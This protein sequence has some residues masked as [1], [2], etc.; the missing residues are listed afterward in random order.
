MISILVV[1]DKPARYTPFVS[2]V[3]PKYLTVENIDFRGNLKDALQALE[4]K[5]YDLVIVDMMLPTNPWSAAPEVDGG[6]TLL[7]AIRTQDEIRRPQ[8]IVGITSAETDAAEVAKTFNDSSWV[9]LRDI[10]GDE[11]WVGRLTDLVSHISAVTKEEATIRSTADV[12]VIT[13][14]RSPEFEALKNLPLNWSDPIPLDSNTYVIEATLAL[15]DESI[16]IVAAS[17]S[18]MGTTEAALLSSKLIHRYRPM[19]IAMTG[20]CAGVENKVNI[21]DVIVG[22]PTWDWQSSKRVKDE[23]GKLSILPALDFINVEREIL[24][25]LELLSDDH[26]FLSAVKKNWAGDAPSTSLRILP[27]PMASGSVLVADG[28]TIGQIKETQ[29]RELLALEMEAY[30]VYAAGRASNKPRPTVLALKAVCDFGNYLKDDKYQRYAAYTSAAC[31]YE[32]LVRF[33]VELKRL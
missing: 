5:L 2:A 30:A 32:F 7:E 13:A 9:L 1:D 31:F 3:T 25:R 29:H 11:S 33:G 14:L 22:N 23:D 21:G 28:T 16:T 27:G 18:R 20:I 19:M 10:S 26:V 17:C 15:G 8:Y 6:A 24:S 12:C 4:D